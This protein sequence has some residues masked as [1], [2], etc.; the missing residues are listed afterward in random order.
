MVI[1]LKTKHECL[2]YNKAQPYGDFDRRLTRCLE[3]DYCPHKFDFGG[4]KLCTHKTS[5]PS[6]PKDTLK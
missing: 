4:A 5:E 2:K 1:H 3:P 6:E